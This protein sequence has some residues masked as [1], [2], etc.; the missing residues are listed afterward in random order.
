MTNNHKS[1]GIVEFMS[2]LTTIN[3]D[4]KKIKKFIKTDNLNNSTD[5]NKPTIYNETRDVL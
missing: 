3:N 2:I 1:H 4:C 5:N